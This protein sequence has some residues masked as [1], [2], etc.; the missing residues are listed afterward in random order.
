MP[1]ATADEVR[2]LIPKSELTDEERV[3]VTRRIDRAERLVRR[4]IA[5]LD[6]QILDGK[7]EEQTVADVIIEAVLR[8][9]RNPEGYLQETDGNYSYIL[10]QENSGKLFIT[11]E[12]WEELGVDATS[13]FGWLIPVL[14]TPRV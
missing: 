10:S 7:L 5:D 2:E 1:F 13:G 12:E 6:Q 4:R 14:R 11:D 3:F 9:V 8:V